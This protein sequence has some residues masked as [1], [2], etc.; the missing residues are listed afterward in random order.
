MHP[1]QNG[2]QAETR[3]E[4]KPLSGLP[5]WFTESG[6]NNV[7][8][9]PG[10]DYFNY[11][12]SEF[13]N[14]LGALGVSFNPNN[15]T[16]LAEG[17]LPLKFSSDAFDFNQILLSQKLKALRFSGRSSSLTP[18]IIAGD[19]ISE[20][21]SSDSFYKKSWAALF[22]NSLSL[23]AGTRNLGFASFNFRQF[24]NH[25][26]IEYIF[27]DITRNGFSGDSF[28]P[29]YYGGVMIQSSTIG[30]SISFDY[31]GKDFCLV[32]A[33]EDGGGEL[34]ISL[35]GTVVGDVNTS[36]VGS[37]PVAGSGDF[38]TF[39]VP[40][41]ADTYKRHSVVITKVDSSPTKLIGCVFFEDYTSTGTAP[42]VWNCG[43][44]SIALAEIP[45]NILDAYAQSGTVIF[46]LGVNDSLLNTDL[47]L[48]SQ[49][50]SY[51]V[52]RC[53]LYGSSPLFLDFIFNESKD[54]NPYKHAIYDVCFS[55]GYQLLDFYEI[56]QGNEADNI[57]AGLLSPDGVHPSEQG[58]RHIYKVVSDY[59]SISGQFQYIDFPSYRLDSASV[60]P[61]YQ[62][63]V[64]VTDRTVDVV[65]I[66]RNSTSSAF[67][68]DTVIATISPPPPR[69]V[70]LLC[71]GVRA[72]GLSE[73][74]VVNVIINSSGEIKLDAN[75]PGN[76][77]APGG[78]VSLNHSYFI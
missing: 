28:Q 22:R 42:T 13:L 29:S 20:G 18:V 36:H 34:S 12:I 26:S 9:Y 76:S 68:K 73:G 43:R 5:G 77:I 30:D 63:D 10:Q 74:N 53:K 55:S 31:V 15:E 48:F 6:E 45:D 64:K 25:P 23:N 50:L 40:V 17:I 32:Y 1:L 37:T 38:G 67:D 65:G 21:T 24:E 59:F 8:S 47:S 57:S 72:T 44:S 69:E 7:P 3:P 27:S 58:H 52:Q 75:V 35:D 2:S 51:F 33:R 41:V 4:K 14:L 16:H 78:W 70:F 66:L 49:K 56:W 11:Q 60:F 39:S 61:G 19:S 54:D 62:F 71:S 46:A